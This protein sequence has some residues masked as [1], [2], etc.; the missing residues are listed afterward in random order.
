MDSIE[1]ENDH[2]KNNSIYKQEVYKR[3]QELD[4]SRSKEYRDKGGDK[5]YE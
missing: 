3:K 5:K 2:I 1:T 4:E